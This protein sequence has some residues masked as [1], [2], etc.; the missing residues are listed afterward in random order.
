MRDDVSVTMSFVVV[1]PESMPSSTSCGPGP[2]S[3][4]STWWRDIR[5]SHA[6]YS[7]S[8]VNMGQSVP[9]DAFAVASAL[10][11]S[12]AMSESRR[13]FSPSTSARAA[14]KA[15]SSVPCSGR[16]MS[17]SASER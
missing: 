9:A 1:E 13:G 10:P 17:P 6:R 2:I 8:S 11:N 5:P 16:M 14:P 3:A 4:V 12:A 15:G 7:S